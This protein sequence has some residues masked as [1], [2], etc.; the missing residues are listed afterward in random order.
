MVFECVSCVYFVF[1]FL[2][3]FFFKQKTAYEMRISDWSSDVCSSDLQVLD[4]VL[5]REAEIGIAHDPVVNSAIETEVIARTRIVCVM[6][7]DHPF[8]THDEIAIRDLEPYPILTYLPQVLFRGYVDKAFSDAGISP[9]LK[10][11]FSVSL[12]GILL[13]SYGACVA[14]IAPPFLHPMIRPKNKS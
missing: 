13:A 5:D 7:D 12:P 14:L 6:R 2:L 9:D 10:V 11:Q 1:V 4:R 8:A 3:F